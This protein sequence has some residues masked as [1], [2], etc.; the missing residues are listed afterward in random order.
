MEVIDCTSINSWLLEQYSVESLAFI[1][2]RDV[3]TFSHRYIWLLFILF[4]FVP[5]F[6]NE[7]IIANRKMLCGFEIVCKIVSKIIIVLIIIP[8]SMGKLLILLLFC[9]TVSFFSRIKFHETLNVPKNEVVVHRQSHHH[10]VHPHHIV[11]GFFYVF[12][13][14]SSVSWT[15]ATKLEE[16]W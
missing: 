3:T 7:M 15:K 10:H 4:L 2:G 12:V 8:W 11:V 9:R 1:H 5:Q 6:A 16:R 13:V 14:F